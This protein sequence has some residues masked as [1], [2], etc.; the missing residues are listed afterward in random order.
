VAA[1]PRLNTGQLQG[2]VLPI[3]TPG[4]DTHSFP[5]GALSR[6]AVCETERGSPEGQTRDR[7]IR[8]HFLEGA[9]AAQTAP[10]TRRPASCASTQEGAAT[11]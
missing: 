6:P 11:P 10:A 9:A 7:A 2:V 3:P 8:L 4:A 5:F 1:F